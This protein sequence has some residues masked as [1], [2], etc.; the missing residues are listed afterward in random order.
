MTL[1]GDDIVISGIGGRFPQADNA[2]EL[3]EQLFSAKDLL[4][5]DSRKLAKGNFISFSLFVFAKRLFSLLPIEITRRMFSLC[6]FL[7]R[8]TRKKWTVQNG[9]YFI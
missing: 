1:D 8:F 3:M 9:L 5:V 6:R 4:T 2:A 7:R